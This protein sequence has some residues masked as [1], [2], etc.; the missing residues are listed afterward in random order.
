MNAVIQAPCYRVKGTWYELGFGNEQCWQDERFK[1]TVDSMR[2]IKND[3][4]E[5]HEDTECRKM[6]SSWMNQTNETIICQMK[7][8]FHTNFS[9]TH[10]VIPGVSING[11]HWGKGKEPKGLACEGKPWIFDYR[12]TTIPACTISEN[13]EQYFALMASDENEVSQQ[14]SCTMS[15]QPDGSMVHSLL[16]PCIEEPKTYCT[17]DGYTDSHEKY[18]IIKPGE[19]V[20]I[21]FFVMSGTP[22]KENFATANVEDIALE[23]LG[24]PFEPAYTTQ[25]IQKLAC[26]FANRLVQTR[27]E[28]KM[29][30]IGQL[31]NEN[32]VFENRDGNEFGWCGQ[33]GMYAK[34]FLK[35]GLETSDSE[36]VEIACSNLDAWSHEAVGKTGLIHTHYHWMME[37]KNTE[38]TCNLGFA[39]F[40]LTQANRIAKE[41]GLD[42]SDWL[43]AAK[44]TA[45][46]L[47]NHYSEEYGFGKAWDVETGECKDPQGT[48][49]AYVIPGL[50]VLWK[51]TNELRYL[52]AAKKACRFYRDRDL[53]EF[54]C[55][56]G[57]LD[58]YCID[59]ESSGPLLAGS[60][61]LYESEPCEEWM[62]CAKM[63]GWYFCSWMF[64]HDTIPRLGS[65]F[66]VYGYRTIGGT[67]VSAQHHH[68]DPWGALV[69]PQLIL[70]YQITG[71]AHWKKRASLMWAN[72]IQNIAPKEGKKIHGLFRAAGAQNEGYHHC[73]WG[74]EGAPGYINEWLVAWPQAFCWNT[75]VQVSDEVLRK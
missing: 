74:E 51:E 73:C 57:A 12:R 20:K 69:V 60:L 3:A 58:T 31:P 59:K 29:F 65:D 61:L 25:Q 71:D 66:D 62:T 49:G 37:G 55:T 18:L 27:N 24:K 32:G 10:F 45:D 72:A 9:F 54:C 64:H 14:A 2:K 42:K 67:S 46:F 17:R 38:D 4:Q 19:C 39:I 41:H 22:I 35:K 52:E 43:A 8:S 6:I 21:S 16:Y 40:E 7:L 23:Q 53:K 56:A 5:E 48:I 28:R 15:P 26:D 1:V 30:S 33:N 47:V 34:L 50:V 13:K 44:S 11:N 68:I 70:L 36:L 63:A 75:A